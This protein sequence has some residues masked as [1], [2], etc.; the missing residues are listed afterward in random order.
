MTTGTKRYIIEII[1]D[2]NN[3][4]VILLHGPIYK[5]TEAVSRLNNLN[6]KYKDEWK[7]NSMPKLILAKVETEMY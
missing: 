2:E 6:K 5:S 4:P 1:K 3:E 7:V